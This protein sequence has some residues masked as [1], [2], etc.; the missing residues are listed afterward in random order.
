MDKLGYEVMCKY[1][2]M[3]ETSEVRPHPDNA[4]KHPRNQ[5][6]QIAQIISQNGWRN[7]IVVSKRSGLVTK[8]HGRLA[9]AKLSGWVK[10]PVEYQD[11]STEEHELADMLADNLIADKGED[12]KEKIKELAINKIA[13]WSIDVQLSGLTKE[14]LEKLLGLNMDEIMQPQFELSPRLHEKYDYVLVMSDNVSDTNFLFDLLKLKEV[15]CYRNQNLV[16]QGRIIWFRDFMNRM[17]EYADSNSI[18]G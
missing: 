7:P 10:V 8:G 11:Y 18:K 16:G 9:A 13:A 4:K 17:K 2:E 1:D 15:T 14:E 12:N 6:L 3:V 5:L